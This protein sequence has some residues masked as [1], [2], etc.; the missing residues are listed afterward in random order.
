MNTFKATAE[1]GMIDACDILPFSLFFGL[2]PPKTS[3]L[4][5]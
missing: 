3:Y 1:P 5:D 4:L 2:N